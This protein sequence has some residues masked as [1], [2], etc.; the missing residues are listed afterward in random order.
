MRTPHRLYEAGHAGKNVDYLILR[1]LVHSITSPI[2]Q[3]QSII[4]YTMH[5]QLCD[6]CLTVPDSGI[7]FLPV[8]PPTAYS[9]QIHSPLCLVFFQLKQLLSLSLSLSLS[10]PHPSSLSPPS[11]RQPLWSPAFLL[12]LTCQASRS[13]LDCSPFSSYRVPRDCTK[14]VSA[15]LSGPPLCASELQKTT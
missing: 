9:F 3:S 7:Y 4:V 15:S 12:A 1:V 11:P 5:L 14:I 2:S 6:G 8:H 10:S 13:S